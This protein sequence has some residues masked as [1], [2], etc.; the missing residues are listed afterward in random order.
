M[1]I[2]L[3]H[4]GAGTITLKAPTSGTVT[5]TLPSA[6]GTSAQVLQTNGSGV[7][8][9][10]TLNPSITDDTTTAAEMYLSWVTT[11][12]GN[13]PIK[14]SSTKLKFNPSTGVL[15]ATGGVTGGTF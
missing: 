3:D 13:L 15:T 12:T 2:P 14:V 10:A 11:T 7:L 8:S 5:F 1:P 4:S 9:F 6:D